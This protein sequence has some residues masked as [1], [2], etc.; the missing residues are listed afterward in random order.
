M[1]ATMRCTDCQRVL[2]VPSKKLGRPVNCPACKADFTADAAASDSAQAQHHSQPCES[3]FHCPTCRKP[4]DISGCA[5]GQPFLCFHCRQ[6]FSIPESAAPSPDSGGVSAPPPHVATRETKPKP[7]KP[8]DRSGEALGI[9]AS[10]L[11]VLVVLGVLSAL[12]IKA[13]AER[14]RWIIGVAVIILYSAKWAIRGLL[15][16]AEV[17]RA[18]SVVSCGVTP[19]SFRPEG[20]KPSALAATPQAAA[21]LPTTGITT[22]DHNRDSAQ[23]WLARAGQVNGP[24]ATAAVLADAQTGRFSPDVHICQVG[25]ERWLPVAVWLKERAANGAV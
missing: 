22:L 5:P 1:P 9:V 7:A 16:I 19:V 17:I 3:A 23:W 2:S 21:T 6:P 12:G 13:N 4:M 18:P 8:T 20:V 14:V 15:K 11:L 25:A 24:Y 10:M